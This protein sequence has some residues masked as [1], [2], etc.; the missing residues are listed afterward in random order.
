MPK[1]TVQE[2]LAPFFARLPCDDFWY[3]RKLGFRKIILSEKIVC[4]SYVSRMHIWILFLMGLPRSHS[5]PTNQE[6]S[7]API[8]VPSSAVDCPSQIV[9]SIMQP[10]SNCPLQSLLHPAAH[11]AAVVMPMDEPFL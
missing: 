5:T 2:I 1:A 11:C 4:I 7:I 8:F 10:P 3:Q 6:P 9:L